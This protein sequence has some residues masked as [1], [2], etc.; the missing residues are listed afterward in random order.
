MPLEG[1][2]KCEPPWLHLFFRGDETGGSASQVADLHQP[3]KLKDWQLLRGW[4]RYVAGYRLLPEQAPGA[5]RDLPVV[6][7]VRA[8][9]LAGRW[10]EPV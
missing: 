2:N 1:D 3:G 9:G 4:I 7:A 8:R 10:G 6:D 5:V